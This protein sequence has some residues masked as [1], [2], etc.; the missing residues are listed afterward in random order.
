ML[1]ITSHASWLRSHSS[2]VH[3]CRQERGTEAKEKEADRQ[4]KRNENLQKRVQAKRDRKNGVKPKKTKSGGGD[5][6]KG[7]RGFERSKPAPGA[8]D[9]ARPKHRGSI[10]AAASKG[11]SASKSGGKK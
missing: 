3:V 10:S 7:A 9:K 11:K 4:K 1:G 2:A 5:K 8:A 6:K